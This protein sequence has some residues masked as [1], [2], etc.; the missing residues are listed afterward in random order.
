MIRVIKVKDDEYSCLCPFH[1]DTNPSLQINIKKHVAHCW[2]GCFQGKLV[3][4][5]AEV[6]KLPKVLAWRKI[7][8]GE[9]FDFT[10]VDKQKTYEELK[11]VVPVN[12]VKW[13]PGDSTKYLLNRGFTSQTINAWDIAYSPDIEH[14]RIPIFNR[15]KEFLAYSY[16]TV[17][18]I[19]PKYIRPGFAKRDGWL[20]GEQMFDENKKAPVNLVEGE[21]DCIWLWQNGYRSS[22]AFLGPPT[23]LQMERVFL[24]GD[25]FRLCFDADKAGENYTKKMSTL[26]DEKGVFY[27]SIKLPDGCDVQDLQEPELKEV[28]KCRKG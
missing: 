2:A 28:M 26:C 22:L 6:E 16:R 13:L 8:S 12:G 9:A 21:L 23:K 10:E 4:L 25:V 14:I 15:D 11:S 5:V 19:Q 1:D 3:D 18:N 20:F 17:K 7:L 24:F 27:K